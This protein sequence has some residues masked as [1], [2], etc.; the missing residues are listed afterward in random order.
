MELERP[1][2][3][4]AA[5]DRHLLFGLLALQNG[6]IDPGDLVAAFQGW[7]RDMSRPLAEHLESRGD[8]DRDDRQAVEALVAR[9]LKKHGGDPDKSL[10]SLA[11]GPRLRDSLAE[12]GDAD[13]E[14]TMARVGGAS[15]AGAD[16]TASYAVGAATSGGQRFRIL[17]PHARGGSG[18]VFVARDGEL[19]REVA[20]KQILDHRADDPLS[21]QRFLIEAEITGGLEHP[22]I[23]PVYGLG[24]DD[25]GRPYYAMRFIRGDSL[26]EAIDRFRADLSLQN[27]PG[28][29]SLA[30]RALLRRFIDVCNAIDYAHSRGILHRDIKPRN[31]IVGKYGETLV[32]DWGLAKPLGRI[33]PGSDVDERTLLPSS[34]SGTADTQAGSALGT[35]A[36]MSPE[37]ACGDLDRLGPRSDVYNLGATLYCLLTGRPPFE[38]DD[39][40]EVLRKVQRGVITRPRQL[41]QSLDK[42]LEAVCLK[43]MATRPEDRYAT[44]RALAEDVDRWMADEPVTAWREP[45]AR[46]ARRWARR[47]RTAVTSLVA[48]V[49]VA[50]VGTGAVLAVQTRA[51]ARFRQANRDL[52]HANERERERFNLAMEAIKLFHGEVGDDLVLKADQFKPLRDKLLDGALEFYGKLERLLEGQPDR[53]SREA[54]GNA[55]FELGELTAKIGDKPAA[56]AAHRKGLAVYRD[57]VSEPS[58]GDA[59][60]GDLARSLLGA[61]GAFRQMGN[62]A[63]AL[64]CALEARDLLEGLPL[65]G[66]GSGRLG[67][68]LGRSYM[69]IGL[70]AAD[71]GNPAAAMTAYGRSVQTLAPLADENPAVSDF[72]VRLADSH[73]NIGILQLRTGKPREAMESYR[74]ALAIQQ[75]LADDDPASPEHQGL[76]ALGHHNIGFLQSNMGDSR[77]AMESYQRA[78]AIRQKLTNVNPAVSD[79]RRRLADS[80]NDVGNLQANTGNRGAAMES[81]RRALA[82][83]QKLADDNPVVSGFRSRVADSHTGIGWLLMQIGAPAD[84]CVEFS[85]EEEIR[86]QLV[87]ESPSVLSYRDLL[88]NCQT[89]KATALLRLARPAEALAL[90]TTVTAR[91]TAEGWGSRYF[92]PDRAAELSEM[93]T[94]QRPTGDGPTCSWRGPDRWTW[95]TQ[96][97]TPAATRR[98]HRRGLARARTFRRPRS[99]AM[100][101][102]RWSSFVAP[103]PWAIATS[104]LTV[105]RPPLMRFGVATTSAS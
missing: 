39:I 33:E 23:V 78:L 5:V 67:A 31:I 100:P 15:S 25:G 92:G 85:R 43:A 11:V 94:A 89:N 75:K 44:C 64:A 74:R 102:K 88:A 32:V 63:E 96:Q 65:T 21:R 82:I 52:A 62:S 87:R 51:N 86:A 95:S 22:G 24:T 61:A 35:P 93:T 81:H 17:R 30:L 37:Q 28:H 14:A 56:V 105:T 72:R 77:A 99:A 97:Y 10:A 73:N 34:P 36:Y 80:H 20:L 40:G 2:M 6:L 29:R 101:P 90:R 41:E 48:S 91:F 3:A 26:N 8:L 13:I 9:H 42:A 18:A 50:L 66:A 55:Y 19:N 59:A 16:P 79:Y 47:N 53:S 104:P 7:T 57:L 45:L 58:A 71:A 12:I 103:W 46:R 76:L 49:L 68:L 60:R 98:S 4:S 69:C 84:A 54:M 1:S 83:R 70:I 38:G 27:D